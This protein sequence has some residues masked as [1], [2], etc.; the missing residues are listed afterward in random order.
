M[1]EK[2]STVSFS[3]FSFYSSRY[4][5]ILNFSIIS[6]IKWQILLLISFYAEG[7]WR[8]MLP[9]VLIICLWVETSGFGKF[10]DNSSTK[11]YTMP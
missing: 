1:L 4:I 10:F 5:K 6:I 8:D 7:L 3:T 9:N 2:K 11:S